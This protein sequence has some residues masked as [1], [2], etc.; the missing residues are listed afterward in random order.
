MKFIA[1]LLLAAFSLAAPAASPYKTQNVMLLQPDFVL[2]DR[3]QSVEALSNY[4]KAAETTAQSALAKES[5]VPTSGFIVFAV[6]PGAQSRVWLD[7]KPALP[8]PV[9]TRLREAIQAIPPFP[10]KNGTVVFAL[11]VTLWDATP[12]VGFPNPPEW[13]KA[14]QGHNEP[15]EIGA[16]VDKLV[17]PK[18]A[19]T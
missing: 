2:K 13:D 16:M 11:N 6:R 14:M 3:V 8:E 5:P 10:A 15:M 17:W 12:R 9:A 4:L 18:G 19:G 1:A 7:F